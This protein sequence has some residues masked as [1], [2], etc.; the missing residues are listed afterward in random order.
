MLVGS[1]KEHVSI[2][3]K[4]DITPNIAPNPNQ[5]MEALR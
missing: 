3:M 5:G 2:A 1:P 4:W